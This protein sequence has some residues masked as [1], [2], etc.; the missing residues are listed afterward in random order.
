MVKISMLST[1]EEVLHGDIVDTNAS[2]LSELFFEQGFA[3]DYRSTVGDQLE[4]LTTEI[5]ALSQRSDVVIVNGGLG[6][7]SDDLS[8]LAAAQ[9]A[10]VALEL[11]QE[12]LA[13][14]TEYFSRIGRPMADSNAKQAMLPQGAIV[15][16]NPVGTACGFSI[17]L[18][19]ALVLFTPGVPFEFK[20]MVRDEILPTLKSRFPD[21]ERL[22]C[23]KIYTFGLGESGIADTLS[24]LD[25]PEAFSLGYRSYMPFIE[26]KVFSP[27]S[28][29]KIE[30]VLTA[31]TEQLKDNVLG[32]NQPLIEVLGDGLMDKQ[33]QLSALE[34]VTGGELARQMYQSESTQQS[35]IQSVVDNQAE[36]LT[37]LTD[38][39]LLAN[40]YRLDTQSD[41]V[42]ANFKLDDESFALALSSK[43]GNYVQNV[44]F[45]RTYPIK[46]QQVLITTVLLDML[47]RHINDES[48]FVEFGHF[49][50]LSVIER[51]Q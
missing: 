18:N 22:V 20:K 25:I 7:T 50:R 37:E 1:G 13:T 41:I 10:G 43:L 27:Y 32:I 16:D 36:P 5:I 29:S 12:W 44:T 3:L 21:V 48:P 35:F 26:V 2:W 17:E 23:N 34:Q 31:I 40:E 42:L 24:S 11:N 6:P 14:I 30:T 49:E 15:I 46:A 51:K 9:A 38:A 39:L 33:W 28:D 8:S 47:R 4:E 45:K 19:G